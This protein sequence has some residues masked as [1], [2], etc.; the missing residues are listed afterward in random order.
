MCKW[1]VH[2]KLNP[3]KP[4]DFKCFNFKYLSLGSDGIWL[5]EP[6]VGHI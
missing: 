1:Y 4:K 5:T 6:T 3:V 2:E